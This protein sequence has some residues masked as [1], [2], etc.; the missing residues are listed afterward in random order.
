MYTEQHIRD[1]LTHLQAAHRKLYAETAAGDPARMS[2]TRAV[3]QQR[4]VEMNGEIRGIQ[5][6]LH[7]HVNDGV[8]DGNQ[9]GAEQAEVAHAT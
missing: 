5:T 2:M 7:E 3:A 9:A 1:Y 4:L 8:L 6:I